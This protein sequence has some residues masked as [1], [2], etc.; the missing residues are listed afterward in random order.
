MARPAEG[1]L[2]DTTDAPRMEA[3]G[4]GDGRGWEG[5]GGDGR[6]EIGEGHK[7]R[8]GT[9]VREDMYGRKKREERGKKGELLYHLRSS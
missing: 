7:G 9:G 8:G 1:P 5:M 3:P 4:R 6:G 2:E